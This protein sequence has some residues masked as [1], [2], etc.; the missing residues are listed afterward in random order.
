MET[1]REDCYK[2]PMK[3]GAQTMHESDFVREISLD[4]WKH[5]D[6][7]VKSGDGFKVGDFMDIATRLTAMQMYKFLY[8]IS[9]L[10]N[11]EEI[12][13]KAE[14]IMLDIEKE[15]DVKNL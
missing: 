12:K 5:F 15:I 14:V 9:S 11:I 10:N 6:D 2:K 7:A 8:E 3:F 1:N 13:A 4:H